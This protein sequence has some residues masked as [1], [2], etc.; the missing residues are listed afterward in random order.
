MKVSKN[1][2]P[3]EQFTISLDKTSGTAATLKLDWA[4]TTA[5]VDVA[6]KK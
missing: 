1:A 2:S 4:G 5:T 3:T 6:E